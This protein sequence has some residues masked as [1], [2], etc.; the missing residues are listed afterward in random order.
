[1]R[2]EEK[3]GRAWLEIDTGKIREN[4]RSLCASAPDGCDIMAVVKADAYGHGAGRV[5][6]LL[7]EEGCRYYAVATLEEAIGLRSAGI[8][9]D[10]LILGY[11]MPRDAFLLQHYDLIQTI[12]DE[13]HGQELAKSGSTVRAHLAVDTGMNRLGIPAK[14][15]E[16]IL[17]LLKLPGIRIEG[18]YSHMS[19]AD[20]QQKEDIAFTN[21]QIAEFTGLKKRLGRMGYGHLYYHCQSSYGFLYYP[22]PGMRFA[23]VGIALYGCTSNSAEESYPVA[24][25]PALSLK[26]RISCVRMVAPG[27]FVSY[28][29]TYEAVEDRKIAAVTIGYADGLPRNLSGQG[30]ALIKGRKAPIIGRICMDQLMLDVTGVAHVQEGDI[31]TF[32]G[33]EGENSILAVEIAELAG[34][35]T[36]ELVS[37]LGSRLTKIYIG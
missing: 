23:R 26:A 33:R 27:E 11:T 22:V 25:K 30:Y 10:I 8:L 18:I 7:Q 1:M 35:I 3:P 14:E 9:G 2:N 4:Y 21:G 37:R 6:K 24:L 19:V 12:V 13:K 31:V 36:N 16:T 15:E 20:S 32:I 34:T 29:R 28:G 5:A 17:R